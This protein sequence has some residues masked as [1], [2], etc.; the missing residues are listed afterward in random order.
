MPLTRVQ[1]AGSVATRWPLAYPPLPED[2]A[3]SYA[4]PSLDD[5]LTAP[6]ADTLARQVQRLAPRGRA[7]NT[8]EAAAPWGSKVQHGIWG[9]IG[10]AL[11]QL[12]AVLTR[13]QRA[14]F[15]GLAD[16]EAIA[17]WEDQHGLP[18]SCAGLAETLPA[19]RKA[20]QAARLAVEGATRNDMLL[21]LRRAGAAPE[22]TITERRGFECGWSGCGEA[23]LEPQEM[24]HTFVVQG[25]ATLTWLECGATPLPYALGALEADV[26]L[27]ALERAKHSHT[28]AVFEPLEA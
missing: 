2:S 19:R 18:E 4:P 23:G 11:A 9:L 1:L 17:D 7:W 5:A 22:V 24:N 8:D 10:A 21:L 12:Y 13:I 20:V 14:A 28:K 6:E 26:P 16:V 3:L 27:C 15:P 25:P